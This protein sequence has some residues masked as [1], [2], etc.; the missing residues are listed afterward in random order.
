M[1]IVGAS[2]LFSTGCNSGSGGNTEDKVAFNQEAFNKQ[3]QGVYGYLD[4][5]QGLSAIFD[6]N[7]LFVFGDT[8]TTMVCQGGTYTTTGDTVIYTTRFASSPELVGSVIRWSAQFMDNNDSVKVVLFDDDGNITQ[9]FY[10]NRIVS[11]DENIVR[12][13][14]KFEGS[15]KY[16][17]HQG[18]G[19]I[20][21]GYL[22]ALGQSD[23]A[24]GTYVDTNDTVTF[25][26]LFSTNP[27]LIG[28][29]FTWV[30]ESMAGDTLNWALINETGEVVSRGK[31]LY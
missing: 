24:A 15:Y 7:F 31:S 19:I 29:E 20:L 9:E 17:S 5:N 4:P 10:N 26:Y 27:D 11:V 3:I 13:L 18:G 28:T 6:N 2:L 16:V 21:S 22:I 1:F 23:G 25:K 30:N 12:Q 14:K 8:D